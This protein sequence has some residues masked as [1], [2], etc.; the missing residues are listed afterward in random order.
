MYS[1]LLTIASG[2]E[3]SCIDCKIIGEVATSFNFHM[4]NTDWMSHL[5]EGITPENFDSLFGAMEVRIETTREIEA[6]LNLELVSDVDIK[7]TYPGL[8]AGGTPKLGKK[9]VKKKKKKLFE[10]SVLRRVRLAYNT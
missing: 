2:F 3:L 1:A 10:V 8:T 9:M 7:F 4:P 6:N 5:S